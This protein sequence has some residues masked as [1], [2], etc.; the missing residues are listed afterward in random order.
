MSLKP[1]QGLAQESIIVFRREYNVISIANVGSKLASCLQHL[2]GGSACYCCTEYGV[3][4]SHEEGDCGVWGEGSGRESW[5][6]LLRLVRIDVAV[7]V[8]E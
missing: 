8:V 1:S 7:N 5:W 6:L 4:G 2:S 3:A